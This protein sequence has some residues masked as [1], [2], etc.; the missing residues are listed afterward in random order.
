MQVPCSTQDVVALTKRLEAAEDEEN[1]Y[2]TWGLVTCK[3]S[4]N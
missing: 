1:V 3:P 2:T 4:V